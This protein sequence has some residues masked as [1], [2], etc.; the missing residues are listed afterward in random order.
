MDFLGVPHVPSRQ[1]EFSP[2]RSFYSRPKFWVVGVPV[3][4]FA[5]SKRA[6]R[7]MFLS[8]GESNSFKI[9]DACSPGVRERF[10]RR[11]G[12]MFAATEERQ[13]R[14][15]KPGLFQFTER[16]GVQ[17]EIPLG[18]L[19]LLS[20]DLFPLVL[21]AF[22]RSRCDKGRPYRMAEGTSAA[23][24]MKPILLPSPRRRFTDEQT[25]FPRESFPRLAERSPWKYCVAAN[26]N[27]LRVFAERPIP[28]PR[29]CPRSRSYFFPR[30]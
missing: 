17:V 4:S 15:R 19:Q 28:L 7:R 11:R 8:R 29:P 30:Q 3:P 23:S 12:G 13:W 20:T 6:L 2:C 24:A 26:E 21:R 14:K 27:T 22:P 16:W 25:Q 10:P 5:K 1:L 18:G 9:H